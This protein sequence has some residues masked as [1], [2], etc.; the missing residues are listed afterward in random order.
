M[1]VGPRTLVGAPVS[2]SLEKSVPAALSTL[3]LARG[4]SC[5]Y[6]VFPLLLVQERCVLTG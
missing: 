6:N 3:G 5:P 4:G 1:A 2:L